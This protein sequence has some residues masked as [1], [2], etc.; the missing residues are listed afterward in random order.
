[1]PHKKHSQSVTQR[2]SGTPGG[3]TKRLE[4]VVK[5]ESVGVIDAVVDAIVDIKA[6]GVEFKVIQSGVGA[7]SKS[8]LVMALTGSRLVVGFEVELMPKLGQFVRENGLEV[9]IYSVIY[10]LI[11]DLKKIARSLLPR[12]PRE[13]ILG[14]AK[15]IAVFKS[16]SRDS[17][18]GCEVQTGTLEVGRDFRIIS[19]MGPIYTGKI[20]SLQIENKSVKH[21]KANQQVGIKVHGFKKAKLGDLVESFKTVHSK[22]L[23]WSPKGEVI[24][25]D[26]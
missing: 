7:I 26:G 24:H 11:E 8:D 19:A 6:D 1:M 18:L 21:A 13:E 15:V 20:E 17:I 25:V 12:R 2:S 4:L 10:D 14:S 3:G 23:T 9:R 22:G 16:G 5:C